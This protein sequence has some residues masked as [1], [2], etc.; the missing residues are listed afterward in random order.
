MGEKKR[1]SVIAGAKSPGRRPQAQRSTRRALK[2]TRQSRRSPSL[3]LNT[4]T[5]ARPQAR[6]SGVRHTGL[7]TAARNHRPVSARPGQHKRKSD[8]SQTAPSHSLPTHGRSSSSSKQDPDGFRA[9]STN[10]NPPAS[11]AQPA[12]QRENYETGLENRAFYSEILFNS[13]GP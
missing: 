9:L 6:A 1:A 2:E 12:I 13:V 7:Y 8:R 4:I 10:W 5:K 3:L 11:T